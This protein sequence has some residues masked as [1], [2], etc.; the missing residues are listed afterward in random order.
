[1]ENNALGVQGNLTFIPPL[2]L[3]PNLW[4]QAKGD[5]KARETAGEW[6]TYTATVH[7]VA[8]PLLHMA[9]Q[10][11]FMPSLS[12]WIN[13]SAS[14]GKDLKRG[15]HVSQQKLPLDVNPLRIHEE[16]E[17]GMQ[18][19]TSELVRAHLRREQRP[20]SGVWQEMGTWDKGT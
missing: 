1:M 16:E 12:S 18:R 11:L 17:P 8:W 10:S 6:E 19:L 13:P 4:E 14:C 2:L 7:V 9:S 3:V 15:K 5:K 20:T